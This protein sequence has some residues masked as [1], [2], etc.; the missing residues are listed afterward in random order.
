MSGVWP[1]PGA[2]VDPRGRQRREGGP[3]QR[4]GGEG[5]LPRSLCLGFSG[6][7]LLMRTNG[8][9]GPTGKQLRVLDSVQRQFRE[10]RGKDTVCNYAKP[11]THFLA[12]GFCSQGAAYPPRPSPL[13]LQHSHCLPPFPWP[14]DPLRGMCLVVDGGGG[15]GVC[16]FPPAKAA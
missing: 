9:R 12:S 15:G 3:R 5:Q 1:L 4:S 6:S 13:I 10:N 11:P 14:S 8:A 16:A 7:R 2:K